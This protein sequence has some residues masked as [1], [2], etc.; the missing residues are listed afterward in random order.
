MEVNGNW[1]G[2]TLL[3]G[4]CTD[5]EAVA[6]LV[7]DASIDLLLTDPPYGVGYSGA[8]GDVP[9]D[10]LGEADFLELLT[11]SFR[12]ACSCMR[13]G[14]CFYIFFGGVS[15]FTFT[16]AL[17][18]AGLDL[19]QVL[20]WVKNQAVLGRSDYQ[21]GYEPCLGGELPAD[22]EYDPI[23]YGWKPGAAH[24]FRYDRKQ[25][26]V[27]RFDKPTKSSLH[28]T[29]KPVPLFDY[30]MKAGSYPGDNIL[31][32]FAGS[33]TALIAG[34]QNGRNV[35]AMEKDPRYADVIISRWEAFT[36]QKAER[37]E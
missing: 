6:R 27:L 13:P 16:S 19:H 32:P 21:N 8:A 10:D 22:G 20:V 23:L 28:P 24:T 11:S 14:A 3:V 18:Q 33:G 36:G 31:D 29:M 25:S 30:L 37:I 15:A 1:G 7:G 35:Y 9:G 5:P 12:N 26:S 17:R 4:D 34:Q 2:G